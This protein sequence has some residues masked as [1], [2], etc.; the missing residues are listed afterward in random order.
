M[1]EEGEE[2]RLRKLIHPMEDALRLLPKIWV[3]DSA[4]EALCSG[5]YLAVPGILQLESGIRKG[6]MVAVMTMKGEAVALMRAEMST[7]EMLE[8]E[9]GIAA[10]PMRVLMPR[11]VY[12][13]MW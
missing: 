4:V 12:P 8:A 5:A 3:R 13:R 9:R 6:S 11:G 10:T 7:E 1:R 2:E